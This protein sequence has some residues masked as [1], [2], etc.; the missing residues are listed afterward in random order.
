VTKSN[1]AKSKNAQS[2]QPPKPGPNQKRLEIFVGK[3]SRRD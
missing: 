3:H 2:K 1:T